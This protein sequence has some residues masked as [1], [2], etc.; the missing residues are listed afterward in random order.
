MIY[1]VIP[2]SREGQYGAG[3]WKD[4]QGIRIALD[5]M[6]VEWNEIRF[7]GTN[8][9]PLAARIGDS[10]DVVIWYYTFWAE[11][12][13]ELK[14]RCPHIHMVLR[15]VNAE[16]RQQ[17]TRARKDWRRLRGLPRDVYGC[18]RLLW[19]DRRSAR[20]A[21]RLAGISPWDDTNYW[22]HL[23]RR[24]SVRSVPYCCPWPALLPDVR[25]GSWEKRESAIAC[26]AGTR[27][28]IGRAHVAGFARLAER[29][30][31]AGWRFMSSSGFGDT[32][33]DSLPGRVEQLGHIEEP[34]SLLC[35][36]KAVAVLSPFG[37]GCKTTVTD[38]LA[39][40]C[41]V[42]VH[43][44]QHARLPEHEQALVIPVDATT[45]SAEDL[46]DIAR[47]LMSDPSRN[48]ETT[49]QLAFE[50]ASRAWKEVLTT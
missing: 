19:R 17:W 39:A 49:Q 24:H 29:P 31:F 43:P 37:Y 5:G 20:A 25:P 8:V 44:R 7:D 41:H 9:T 34:W 30:E 32:S 47:R 21:S 42:L 3:Q 12:M 22:A 27:D 36:I 28:P 33:R 6:N 50:R 2:E 15:T 16:A 45:T 46:A 35:G 38:A 18:V 11:A 23:A 10:A 4:L 14:C 26:L 40:G 48:V 1:L 13:E